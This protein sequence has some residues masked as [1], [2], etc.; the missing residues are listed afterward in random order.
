MVSIVRTTAA[1]ALAAS[2]LSTPFLPIGA[3]L[4][5]PADCSSLVPATTARNAAARGALPIDLVRLRDMGSIPD[6]REPIVSVS[7]DGKRLAFE[8]HQADPD[9]NDY[10]QGLFV[11]EA[12]AGAK[13]TRVDEIRSILRWRFPQLPGKADYPSGFAK[14][15]TPRWFPDNRTIA[16]LKRAGKVI[17]VWRVDIDGSASAPITH[18][19][20]DVLDF[21]VSRDGRSIV[22]STRPALQTAWDEM[23]RE[24][25]AGF[26]FDDR[27]A[28]NASP[29]PFPAPPISTETVALDLGSGEVRSTTAVEAAL[30]QDDK[31]L[32]PPEAIAVSLSHTGSRAWT[33]PTPSDRFPPSAQLVAQDRDGNPVACQ[34]EACRSVT[35]LLGWSA[36]G[37]RIRFT[38][39][40]GWGKSVTAIYEWK[41]GPDAPKRRYA[42]S[43]LL[44]DCSPLVDDLV[45][46]EEGSRTPRHISLL[47]LRAGTRQILF[48]PNPEFTSLRLG[49]VERLN[50][51]TAYG[52]ESFGDLVYPVGYKPGRRYPLVVVQYI[53]RGFLRGGT[54]DEFPIQA[55][56]NRG[57]LV[58]SIQRPRS[59]ATAPDATSYTDLDKADLVEFKDRKNVLSAIEIAVRTLID[60]GL[61][62]P[63]RVGITGLS[64]GASTVQFAGLHSKLFAVAAMSSCCWERSQMALLGPAV[65]R[66]YLQTGWPLQSKDAPAFWD[67]ISWAQQPERVAFPVLMQLADAELLP[68]LEAYTALKEVGSPVDLYVYPDEEHVKWQPVHRLAVYRRNLDWFD[69]WLKGSAPD[70]PPA[71]ISRWSAM[72]DLMAER[73]RN[74]GATDG[75]EPLLAG[76]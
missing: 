54:G 13:A 19:A 44:V 12:R 6:M 29:R 30:L 5:A 75:R 65:A 58:L 45:C 38:R 8:L 3:A 72:K 53:S 63:A 76:P 57:Y 66:Q 62:D 60:R 41:P 24:G 15:I 43:N 70:A 14:V 26:H 25:L 27:F 1:P 34:A 22:Y 55:F 35:T 11:M 48:D 46:V 2:L 50:W 67:Q 10:C 23:D 68:S 9:S 4:A 16:F 59:P 28:P 73:T 61:V 42:T 37:E 7:P 49:R 32:G 74:T 64:D 31:P 33:K 69:F 36:D 20:S 47:Q 18:S 17:Q 40:E 51:K 71:E 52:I 21:R 39:L 56:A